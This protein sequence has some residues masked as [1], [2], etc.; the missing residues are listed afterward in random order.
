LVILACYV[1]YLASEYWAGHLD[2]LFQEVGQVGQTVNSGIDERVQGD[3][4][5]LFVA[6]VRQW[7]AV[8]VWGLA[9]LGA[10]RWLRR[11]R[12]DLAFVTLALAPFLLLLGQ[13]YGGEIFLRIYLLAL[14]FA[15]ILMVA[16]FVPAWPPRRAVLTGLLVCVLSLGLTG[17]FFIARYGNEDFERVRPA[18]AAAVDWLYA[19]ARPGTTFVAL[20]GNVNWRSRAVE[21]YD[22]TPLTS[23]PGPGTVADIEAMMAANPLGAYLIITEGQHAMVES[24]LDRPPGWGEEIEQ[25]VSTSDRFRLVYSRDGA[26]IFV[27]AGPEGGGQ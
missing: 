8:V 26:K 3:P 25:Q 15:A 24:V 23:Q 12:G 10:W 9:A 4:G 14:P 18:D 5:H 7:L 6:Q 13:S 21:R 20:T 22:H 11:G 17:G 19:N 16:L 1:S 2:D 27:L